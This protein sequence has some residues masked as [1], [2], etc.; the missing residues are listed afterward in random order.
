MT[1]SLFF[2]GAC[3][4]GSPELKV[5]EK[6]AQIPLFPEFCDEGAGGAGA[7]DGMS[8]ELPPPMLVR[9]AIPPDVAEQP[10]KAA[11]NNNKRT[12]RNIVTPTTTHT[13]PNSGYNSFNSALRQAD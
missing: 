3:T 5:D 8:E 13:M 9:D 12:A 6:L 2:C 10:A 11:Q 1:S 7:L 4:G